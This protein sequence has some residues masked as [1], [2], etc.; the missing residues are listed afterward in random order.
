MLVEGMQLVSFEEADAETALHAI[1][2]GELPLTIAAFLRLWKHGSPAYSRKY[3]WL[4]LH[5]SPCEEK[6]VIGSGMYSYKNKGHGRHI[7]KE[8]WNLKKKRL[9]LKSY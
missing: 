4:R 7:V 8:T 6:E 2:A 1:V 5:A 3:A 9:R